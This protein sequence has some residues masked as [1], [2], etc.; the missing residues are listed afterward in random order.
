ME[1]QSLLDK[2]YFILKKNVKKS[3]DKLEEMIKDED[4]SK[5]ERKTQNNILKRIKKRYYNMD[6]DYIT[7]KRVL[8]NIGKIDDVSKELMEYTNK[9][10]T[11]SE[12]NGI[13]NEINLNTNYSRD[14]YKDLI[15][16]GNKL[17][18]RIYNLF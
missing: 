7:I 13:T 5:K 4:L 16:K 3:I 12:K 9:L 2:E 17:K 10:K 14:N 8:S 18:E 6:S 1:Y 15:E 11:L